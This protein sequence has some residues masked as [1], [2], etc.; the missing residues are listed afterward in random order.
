MDI[1]FFTEIEPYLGSYAEAIVS[2][3]RIVVLSRHCKIIWVNQRFCE[4]TKY[5]E[6]E[7][8]GQSI[9]NLNL[10]IAD[11]NFFKS[12]YSII[13]T[14]AR[15]SGELKCRKRDDTVFWVKATV[16]PAK[17]NTKKIESYLL[18]ISDITPTKTAL[19]EKDIALLKIKQGEARYRAL[20]ETQPDFIS[21]CKADGTRIFVNESYCRFYGKTFHE[22]IGTNIKDIPFKGMPRE[23]ILSTPLTPSQPEFSGIFQLENAEGQKLWISLR[24]KGIFDL[25]GV[26]EEFLTIGRDVTELKDAEMQKANYIRDLEHIAFMTSHNVRGPISTMLGL[27]ELMRLNAIHTERWEEIVGSFRKCIVD[28]DTYTREMGAFIY[29]RQSDEQ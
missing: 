8:V 2:N 6:D 1:S 23:L 15:W 11:S 5:T 19:E 29:T 3:V 17:K 26:L 24:V 25:N 10:V 12:T 28:L 16:L 21:L 7:L 4:L 27:L 18:L 14:G 13:S 9:D 22:L 20:V